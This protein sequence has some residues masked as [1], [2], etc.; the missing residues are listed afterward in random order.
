MITEKKSIDAALL[1][2]EKIIK[3]VVFEKKIRLLIYS[4]LQYKN[5][6]N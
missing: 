4:K 6:I 1:V 3:H 2:R 5:V